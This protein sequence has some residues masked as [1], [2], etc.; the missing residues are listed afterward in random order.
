MPLS[1]YKGF[2]LT[3]KIFLAFLAI[4][5]LTVV[6]TTVI[7]YL[8]LKNSARERSLTEMQKKSETLMASLD[9]AVSHTQLDTDDL[10]TV[11]QNELF[12]IS[13]INK[14]DLVLYD[15]KG[16][17]LMSNKDEKLVTQRE[18]G[19]PLVNEILSKEKR[20]DVTNYD[21]QTKSNLT[22]SY[23]ILRLCRLLRR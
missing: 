23:Q 18:I 17:F 13:D 5:I 21:T 10:P 12:K 8:V 3:K 15:L 7:S 9:Y 2:N 14:Q 11:L 19:V 22:S 16:Q 1:R 4:A 6:G 20:V